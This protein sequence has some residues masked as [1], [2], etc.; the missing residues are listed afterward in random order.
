MQV[1]IDIPDDLGGQFAADPDQLSRLVLEALAIHGVRSGRLTVA[2]ARRLIGI[3]SRYEMDGFLKAH[4]VVLET[5][6]EEIQRDADRAL[7]F[8]E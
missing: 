6:I 4:G 1:K 5:S 7:N 2:Q 3:E 8:A